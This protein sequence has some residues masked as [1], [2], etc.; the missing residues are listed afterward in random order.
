MN[1]VD[2]SNGADVVAIIEI[3]KEDWEYVFD[4]QAEDTISNFLAEK[5]GDRLHELNGCPLFMEASSW[6]VMAGIGETYEDEEF[7]I[8]IMDWSAENEE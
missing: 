1:R 7:E 2:Y 5:I 6:C 4:A 3:S 8:Y